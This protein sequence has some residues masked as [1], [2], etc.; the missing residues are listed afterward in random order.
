MK[1]LSLQ[2]KLCRKRFTNWIHE[3]T[4]ITL[5]KQ[6]LPTDSAL[7]IKIPVTFLT[8]RGKAIPT[9][10]R[11]TPPKQIV[12]GPMLHSHTRLPDFKFYIS[13]GGQLMLESRQWEGQKRFW[14]QTGDK[15]KKDVYICIKATGGV[16]GNGFRKGGQATK[17]SMYEKPTMKP[18]TISKRNTQRKKCN[19]GSQYLIHHVFVQ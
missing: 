7:P 19:S 5:W 4:R 12:K 11:A 18:I 6:K 9:L 2:W 15:K 17:W 16:W 3:L 13:E 10:D 14:E 1:D 8:K